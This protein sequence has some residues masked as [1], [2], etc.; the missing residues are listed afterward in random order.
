[1]NRTVKH[2]WIGVNLLFLKNRASGINK[3]YSGNH[4]AI[5]KCIRPTCYKP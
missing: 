1:M 3:H 4:F 2:T 5:H